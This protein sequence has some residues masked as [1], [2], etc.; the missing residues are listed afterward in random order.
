MSQKML[1]FSTFISQCILNINYHFIVI[2]GS[3][4][5]LKAVLRNIVYLQTDIKHIEMKQNEI[6]NK[7]EA[8]ETNYGNNKKQ[9]T[10]DDNDNELQEF[11]FP[12]D[13][14]DNLSIIEDKIN[15][16][17]NLKK[18]LVCIRF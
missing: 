15:T 7:L 9:V 14:L 8:I 1:Y 13:D 12:I 3:Q 17:S 10:S 5:M 2:I 11:N 18:C 16:N 6:L 4:K